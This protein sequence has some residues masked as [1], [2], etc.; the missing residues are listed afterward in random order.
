M[1]YKVLDV[2]TWKHTTNKTFILC[3]IFCFIPR[4]ITSFSFY[5]LNRADG[6]LHVIIYSTQEFD[7]NQFYFFVHLL[8]SR[9]SR[10]AAFNSI[11]LSMYL[12]L[13][14]QLK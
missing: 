4:Y 9:T 10:F 6:S 3:P 5:L 14:G 7:Q 1:I 8:V 12:L 2:S 13:M 11:L